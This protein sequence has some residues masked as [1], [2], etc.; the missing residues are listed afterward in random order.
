MPRSIQ[1]FKSTFQTEIARPNRFDVYIIPPPGLNT[2]D[3]S[4]TRLT[5]RCE[6]AQ[7]PGRTFDTLDQR[8]YGPIEKHPYLTTYTDLDLTFIVDGDMNEK[9]FFDSWLEYINP[10]STNNYGYKEDYTTEL[11]INQYD[12]S[13]YMT[14][15]VRI[16]DA[17]PLS[18]NQ[19][20]LDWSSDGYHKL[21]VTFAY[22][23]WEQN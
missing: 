15:S 8:T 2:I 6:N 21:S 19:L 22:T 7:L 23:R 12:L 13:N 5:Y 10:H 3:F 4:P 14:Y 1:N 11:I 16:I 20:D 9:Y 18:V 17:Y